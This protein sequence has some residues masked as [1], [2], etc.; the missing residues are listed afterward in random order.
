[1]N[2][3]LI[4]DHRIHFKILFKSGDRLLGEN[5][6]KKQWTTPQDVQLTLSYP[7]DGIGAVITYLEVIVDQVI[8][9]E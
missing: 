8:S 9:I 6:A 5:E 1:M 3:E 4:F 7:N 2:V